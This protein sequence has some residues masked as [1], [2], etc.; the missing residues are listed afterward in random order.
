MHALAHHHWQQLSTGIAA[1]C[2][3]PGTGR[4]ELL[5]LLSKRKYGE[6]MEKEL[7]SKRKLT[8]STLGM[9]FHLRDVQGLGLV[10][11]TDTPSGPVI[12]LVRKAG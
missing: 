2:L 12:R 9:Q 1:C 11:K 6:I 3:P 10:A 8:Q 5:S 7:L 4:K